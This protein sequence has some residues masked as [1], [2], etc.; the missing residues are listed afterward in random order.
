RIPRRRRLSRDAAGPPRP[1]CSG[2]AEV[3]RFSRMCLTQARAWCVIPAHLPAHPEHPR[4]QTGAVRQYGPLAIFCPQPSR[5]GAAM[6]RDSEE[7]PS[8]SK[9]SYRD[10]EEDREDERPARKRKAREDEEDERP[11]RKGQGDGSMLWLL[12]GGGVLV[13]GLVA[14]L[15]V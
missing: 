15:V 5:R 12:L 4:G 2:V 3:K 8:K 13:V 6:H 11:R 1:H 14:V 10:E 9:R 7:R